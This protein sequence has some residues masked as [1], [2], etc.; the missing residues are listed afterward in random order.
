MLSDDNSYLLNV[1]VAVRIDVV[2][3]ITRSPRSVFS[4]LKHTI[5]VLF[6]LSIHGNFRPGHK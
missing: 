5:H 4:Y 6:P 3:T 2:Y 1:D